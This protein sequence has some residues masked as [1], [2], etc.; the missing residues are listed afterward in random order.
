[1][2]TMIDLGLMLFSALM[3]AAPVALPFAIA[4]G[5]V[6]VAAGVYATSAKPYAMTRRIFTFSGCPNPVKCCSAIGMTSK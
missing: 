5:A 6:G 4:T 3:N 1:M 2:I